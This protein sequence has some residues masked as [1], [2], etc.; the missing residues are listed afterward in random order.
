MKIKFGLNTFGDVGRD[1]Q[2]GERLSYEQAIRNIIEEGKLA[3]EVGVDIF[4]VGEHHRKEYAI[5]SPDTVLAALASVT[6]KITLGTAVTVLSS[7]DPIR[8]YQRFTTINAI[9]KGRAQ[10]M[11]GR[12][13][14]TESYP[15]FGYDLRDYNKLFEEKILLFSKLVNGGPINNKGVFTPTL[16]KMI[17][18]P[19]SKE[20]KLDVAVGVGGSPDS[21]VRAA[22]F[23]YPL[24]LAII[25]GNP[26]RFKPY[27]QL[28]QRS[29]ESFGHPAQSVGMHSIGV[30]AKTDEEARANA[31]KY[32]VPLMAQLGKERGWRPMT[33]EQFDH[34]LE[35]GSMY[36]G[37]PETVARRIATTIKSMGVDRFDLV[38][39]FGE[40][41]QSERFETVRLYGEEVIPLVEKLL[42][43]E[44]KNA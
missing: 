3:E 36:V 44:D 2:S 18:Y 40:Q 7:D 35:T 11:L 14:F 33:R 27:I 5:S 34:E 42:L 9:A 32:V 13:S 43:E 31:W 4:A 21:V 25:G 41:L 17:V 23:G 12:G 8:L 39:G 19:L 6:K 28:Y 22:R 24:M 38:Y 37:S 10:I 29:L 20:Y 1:D 15:L 30:I 16:D 26:T